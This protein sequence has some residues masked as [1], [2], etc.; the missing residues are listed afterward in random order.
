[1]ADIGLVDE[2]SSQCVN[3]KLIKFSVSACKYKM[4]RELEETLAELASAKL[5]YLLKC[6]MILFYLWGLNM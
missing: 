1:M 4:K 6:K 3:N 2:N 5:P